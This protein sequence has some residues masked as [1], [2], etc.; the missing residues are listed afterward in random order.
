MTC[1]FMQDKLKQYYEKGVK[2]VTKWWQELKEDRNLFTFLIFLVLSTGFW[3]LN[4]LQK[5]Y[6]TTVEY[7]VEFTNIPEG[8]IL[9]ESKAKELQLKVKAGGFNI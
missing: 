6:T 1:F 7:P 3:F 4:A 9:K 5:D 2:L 8:F